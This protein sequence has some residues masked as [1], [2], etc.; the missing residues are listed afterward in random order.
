[1]M[2]GICFG[3]LPPVVNAFIADITQKAS[4]ATAYGI[5]NL[6][7]ILGQTLAPIIGGFLAESAGLKASFVAALVISI[8]NIILIFK[9]MESIKESKA[10]EK[11]TSLGHEKH[12]EGLTTG[13]KRIL[14]LFGETA[15]CWV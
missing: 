15:S 2:V 6:S 4:R 10:I 14:F 12:A 13:Y 5:F 8:A 9:V 3:I 11:E 1:M 7:W